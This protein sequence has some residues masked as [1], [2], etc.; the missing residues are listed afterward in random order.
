MTEQLLQLLMVFGM[1][2]FVGTL[3]RDLILWRLCESQQ[4]RGD[5]WFDRYI[6]LIQENSDRPFDC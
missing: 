4:D 3:R 2:Y 1:G 6:Q 5:Y